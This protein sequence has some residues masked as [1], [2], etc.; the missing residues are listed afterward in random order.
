MGR[1][2][3]LFLLL[4]T[5]ILRQPSLDA[6]EPL[7][8]VIEFNRD[9][10]PI[11]SDHCF[12]C[13]GPDRARRKA[14]LRLDTKE[15]AFADLGG[16]RALVPGDPDKS[17][18]F[19]RITTTNDHERMPPAKSGRRLT[20][21]QILLLRRWIEQGAKWQAHWS[22][23][24]PK[25]PSLPTVRDTAWPRTPIDYFILARLEREGLRPSPEAD[26]VTLLR[27]VT[28]D[29]TGLPPTPAEVDA[30]LQDRSPGAYEKAVDRLLASPRYG[31]RMA[32]PWLN[33]AR[34]ADTNGYQSDGERS[35]WRWRDWV[36]EA[37]NHNMPF[38]RFT[39]EQLAGDM[40]PGATLEQRIASGF[41]RNHRGNAEGGI[42]P[43]E[44]AVEYVVDR[45][46]TTATVWLG[47]TLGC[48]R[49]HD[50]K[51]DPVKQK[52]FYRL[53]AYFNNVPERGKAIK[54]GNSPPFIKTPTREQQEQLQKLQPRLATAE[55]RYLELE[56]RIV[57][58]QAKW[59]KSL[60][61]SPIL[62]GSIQEDMLAHF[63][64]E[65]DK[66][67][68]EG[69]RDFDAGDV[70]HFGYY[71]KFSLAAW[72][73]PRGGKGGT[74]LSRMVDDPQA[75]GYSVVLKNGQIQVNLV[76]R[77]LDDAIRVHTEA[78]IAADRD[79]H[80]IVTY[81]G[82]R[83][84]KGI[85]VYLDG[86]PAKVVVDLDDLNQNFQSKEPLRIGAGHGPDGRFHGT[87]HDVRIYGRVLSPEDAG[88][89]PTTDPINAIAARPFDQRTPSQA[90]KIRRHF[91]NHAAPLKIQQAREQ[92]L[93]LRRNR[94]RLIESFPTT[95]VMQEMPVPRDTFVLIRGEYD[96]HGE[97]VTPGVPAS[98]PPL[99]AAFP[100]NR[101][102]LARWLVNPSN[103]L[104]ARVTV[105]RYWQMLFGTG[106]VKTVED[107]GSQGEWPTH[108]EL[109]DWLA[110]E[111]LRRGWDVKA[112]LRTIVTS[113]AYR[114]SS[115]VSRELL[116][117]DLE[118]R[119]LARG[120]RF[121]LSAE[122]VRD[123]ALFASGLLVEKLGG[124][125]VKTYQPASLWKELA[126]VEYKPDKG[127]N[128][129][130]RSLYTFWK[131]TVAPPNMMTFDAAGRE[132]C[133][134]RQTRTNTPLQA[135]TLMNDV[136]YVEA[137]RVLAERVLRE[138]HASP[139]QRLTRMFRLLLARPPRSVELKVL[140]ADLTRH[141]SRYRR[142]RQAA[143]KLVSVGEA[144]RDE[145]LNVAELATYTAVANL[146]LNLDE[147]ITRE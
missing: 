130:R 43:E 138:D 21:R 59:E 37:F 106:L 141:L 124:P 12:Q 105:N 27:R 102:G 72:V 146:I 117:R 35:M 108:P 66:G 31:E 53:F 75:A 97:K 127:D 20:E 65:G 79:C 48:A 6:A 131:R 61:S 32:L 30:F 22:F 8:S 18:L 129:Y 11:L 38:D 10:R 15:G 44:Y 133:I 80:L 64:L 113:A 50:H 103:P 119:L 5:L 78:R 46:D 47:L 26:R 145:K 96:K 42:I 19:H 49:C 24:A 107:F 110:T 69:R 128:L 56:P 73:R 109:L 70:G 147:T 23:L 36:I 92:L 94:D 136:T 95:M 13:H 118:N 1:S 89:L 7:P 67:S 16:S 60:P 132:T 76:V 41:N 82:S 77:W 28:L 115:K 85:T 54:Y 121:R 17:E 3:I 114:Q 144:K 104:T 14:D 45:V 29:L 33:A 112:I 120:P 93:T 52:E 88:I 55:H 99:P 25:R 57:A 122:M 140:S 101:L 2:S 90:L 83:V 63:P 116:R 84:A 4:L 39:I 81:D 91:L 125:S 142:D 58:A 137:A 98:L 71:D 74:I 134:V 9:I 126:N 62:D 51:F 100:N 86:R 135:L 111:L 87:I 139:E 68:F 34:Y 40:L 143:L 123:Q